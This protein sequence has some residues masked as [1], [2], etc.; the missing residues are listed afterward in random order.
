[1]KYG[2]KNFHFTRKAK[3]SYHAT[4]CVLKKEENTK[5]LICKLLDAS[6]VL[7]MVFT[8]IADQERGQDGWILVSVFYVFLWTKIKSRSI[9][10]RAW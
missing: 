8:C 2:I 7:S 6:V 10:S 9:S 4:C 3:G 1:M 5:K